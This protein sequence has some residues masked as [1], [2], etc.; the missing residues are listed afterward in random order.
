MEVRGFHYLECRSCALVTLRADEVTS[1]TSIYTDGYF[2][3]GTQSGYSNYAADEPIHR[4]NARRHLSRMMR[5]GARSP[6]ILLD[7]GCAAGFFLNE[8]EARGWKVFGV[9]ISSWSRDYARKRFGYTVFRSIDEAR[10][11]LPS[12][13]DAITAFQVLEHIPDVRAAFRSL[14][15]ALKPGGRLLVETWNRGSHTARF[16]GQAWQQ[17]SPPSVVHLL[18]GSSLKVLLKDSGFLPASLK[19]MSKFL[20]VAWAA[21]LVGSRLGSVLVSKMADSTFLRGIPLPYFLDDLVYLA[22][23]SVDGPIPVPAPIDGS[24]GSP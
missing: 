1:P 18:N 19:P 5:S 7:V 9:D 11:S 3:R 15:L 21:G 10:T 8:A 13:F 17:L 14:R 20:S 23:R 24:P 22:T 4:L 12:G 2:E 16:V 6:G